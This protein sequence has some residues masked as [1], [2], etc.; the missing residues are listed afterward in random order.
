MPHVT[1][2]LTEAEAE[3]LDLAVAEGGFRSRS[4][5]LREALRVVVRC[6]I[7]D[8]T[9]LMQ[10]ITLERMTSPPRRNRQQMGRDEQQQS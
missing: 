8:H 9:G 4:D 2:R 3:A 10:R 5:A 1:L 6:T 7:T